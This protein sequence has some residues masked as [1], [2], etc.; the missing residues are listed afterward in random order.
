MEKIRPLG[1]NEM[2]NE[3]LLE[4][5]AK[6]DEIVDFVNSVSDTAVDATD[7]DEYVGVR[8][9]GDGPT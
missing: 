5:K 7:P 1:K 3:Y 2:H 6:L 4:V 8:E 9:D